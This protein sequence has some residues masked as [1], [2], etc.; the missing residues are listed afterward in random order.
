LKDFGPITEN[1]FWP[2]YH[3]I[4]YFY[5]IDQMKYKYIKRLTDNNWTNS[6]R[7]YIK[8]E[9]YY[10]TWYYADEPSTP[11]TTAF[12]WIKNDRIYSTSKFLSDPRIARK[13][14]TIRQWFKVHE[15]NS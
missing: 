7:Y 8:N 2:K 14:C 4:Y 9:T 10:E 11:M 6:W 3:E 1:E 15:R 13:S 5:D 12:W